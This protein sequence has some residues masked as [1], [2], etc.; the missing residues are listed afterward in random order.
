MSRAWSIFTPTHLKKQ[1][2][3]FI[4]K[5]ICGPGATE[6]GRFTEGDPV[7]GLQPTQITAKWCN[8]VQSICLRVFEEFHLLKSLLS[9]NEIDPHKSLIC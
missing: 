8:D 9:G 1:T 6:D 2:R 3:R 5:K 4:M 7:N